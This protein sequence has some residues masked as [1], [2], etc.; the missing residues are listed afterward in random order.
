MIATNQVT[1]NR[2]LAYDKTE[3]FV[4]K[5]YQMS[6]KNISTVSAEK[7]REKSGFLTA[8]QIGRIVAREL[9]SQHQSLVKENSGQVYATDR[10]EFLDFHAYQSVNANPS[11][12]SEGSV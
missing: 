9:I 7:S 10:D 3:V 12:K 2:P 8:S 1:R 5:P 4:D 11:N 6:S